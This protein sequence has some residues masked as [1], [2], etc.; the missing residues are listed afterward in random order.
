MLIVV[1]IA[2]GGCTARSAEPGQ[3]TVG[4]GYELMHPPDVPNENYP[5]GSHV[6]SSAPLTS[7]HH[8]AVFATHEECESSRIHRIDDSIDKARGEVGDQAKYQLPVRRAV[9]ARCVSAR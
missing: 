1:L 7:W 5:G 9:N 4:Q 3:V 2:S 8:V 6:Q